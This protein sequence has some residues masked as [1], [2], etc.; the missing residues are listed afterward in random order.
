MR[1]LTNL[2]PLN[3]NADP[4]VKY[5][6]G[7]TTY[8]TS[9]DTPRGAKPGSPLMLDLGKVGELAEVRVNGREVG[10]VWHAPFKIDVG[11]A[12]RPG[13]NR[14]EVKVANLW[15]NRLIGDAQTG[16]KKVTFTTMPTYKPDAPLRASGLI[17][18]VT[19]SKLDD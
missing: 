4:Q 1:R 8:A 18:P 12:V 17:G 2:A 13:R 3:E 7:V 19:L 5:F 6:S 9:F 11:A 15:V 16:A 14:L 10:T